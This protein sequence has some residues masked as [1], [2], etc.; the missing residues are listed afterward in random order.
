MEESKLYTTQ[1]IENLKQKIETYRESLSSLK[2]GS[3]IE[4]FL[5]MKQ[6]FDGLKTQIAHLEGITE[7]LDTKQNSY[8]KGYDDQI[9][10]LSI[11]IESLNQTMEEMNQEILAVLNKLLTVEGND[12]T[13]I[14]PA[15]KMPSQTSATHLPRQQPRMTQTADKTTITSAQPSY[16]LLQS[17]AGKAINHQQNVNNNG[18]PPPHNDQQVAK[19]EERHFNQQYFQSINT[20]PSHIYNGLFRN[21]TV[22]STFHF[23]NATDAKEVPVSVYDPSAV[24][25]TL[26]EE[27]IENDHLLSTLVHESSTGTEK[28]DDPTEAVPTENE[29]NNHE[30]SEVTKGSFEQV[31]SEKLSKTV[32]EDTTAIASE[33]LNEVISE[34]VAQ[35]ADTVE[36]HHSPSIE[37]EEYVE[38]YNSEA[39]YEVHPSLE[40]ENKQPDPVNMPIEE[41]NKKGKNSFF[42]FFKRWS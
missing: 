5:Y 27:N 20:H 11:Q 21:T 35:P 42:D 13:T 7:T 16:R 40:E 1:E 12:T 39:V 38:V 41:E 9:R 28:S 10:L 6:G 26:S 25:P 2:T 31:N 24:Q 18:A 33:P 17:L 23:K 30:I 22:E 19:P 4:D 15:I 14:S 32:S 8:I 34:T 36:T 37:T 29:R 3:S